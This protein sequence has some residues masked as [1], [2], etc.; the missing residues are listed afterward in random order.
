MIVFYCIY[1][2]KDDFGANSATLR[3]SNYVVPAYSFLIC[4]HNGGPLASRLVI[5]HGGGRVR[6]APRPRL[7]ADFAT[8]KGKPAPR[9]PLS[10]PISTP[11][12][13]RLP[14]SLLSTRKRKS[15]SMQTG[16]AIDA[17]RVGGL[18]ADMSAIDVPDAMM[19]TSCR[20]CQR[21]LANDRLIRRPRFAQRAPPGAK[22]TSVP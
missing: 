7:L 12:C 17:P 19:F 16:A 10:T 9:C 2:F 11:L 6:G 5:G 15:S 8:S 4:R 14:L 13:P 1:I 3:V 18:L 20:D 22:W 21:D